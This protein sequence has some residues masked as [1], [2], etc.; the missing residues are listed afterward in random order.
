MGCV[1]YRLLRFPCEAADSPHLGAQNRH[2]VL[3][4]ALA[5]VLL[6]HHVHVVGTEPFHHLPERASARLLDSVRADR[7][8]LLKQAPSGLE[9]GSRNHQMNLVAS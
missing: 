9:D 6:C 1:R 5:G 7:E 2:H 3:A 8:V 4:P